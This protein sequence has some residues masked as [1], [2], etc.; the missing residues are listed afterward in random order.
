MMT[1]TAAIVVA[2][3]FLFNTMSFAQEQYPLKRLTDD[4]AQAGFATWSPDGKTIIY[5][6]IA[7]SD[8]SPK[9]GLWKISADGTGA[10]HFSFALAEHPK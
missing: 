1:K 5:S 9:T 7:R 8:T 6:C 2:A 10:K 3:H 4:P